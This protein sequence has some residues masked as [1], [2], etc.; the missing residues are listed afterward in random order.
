M[1]QYITWIVIAVLCIVLIVASQKKNNVPSGNHTS[2]KPTPVPRFK[3]P[4]ALKPVV[5]GLPNNSYDELDGFPPEDI[6]CYAKVTD[7]YT[8]Q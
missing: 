8:L 3:K 7:K 4:D 2:V 1:D 5:Q 6:S